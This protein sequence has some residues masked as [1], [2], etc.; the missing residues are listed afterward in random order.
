MKKIVFHI[1]CLE[2]GGAE[3]VVTNLAGQFVNH[4]YEVYIATESQGENEYETDQRQRIAN[5]PRNTLDQ[6][7]QSRQNQLDPNQAEDAPEEHVFAGC[8]PVNRKPLPRV[9]PCANT[10]RGLHEPAGEIF[11]RATDHRA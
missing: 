2:R 6:S 7:Q 3:R 5:L 8:T 11:E 4:G 1:Q 9:I 10:E